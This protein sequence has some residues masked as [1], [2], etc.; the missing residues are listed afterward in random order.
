MLRDELS[1]LFQLAVG[2]AQKSG[3][4]PAFELPATYEVQR[5]KQAEHGDYSCNAAMII[6]AAARKAGANLNPRQV[7]Q[8]ILDYLP[9]DDEIGSAEIA[10]PGFIN[11]RLGDGW[12]QQQVNTIVQAD[13]AFGNSQRG[14]GQYWQVEFVSANPTGPIHY[15]GA[16][17]AVLGESVSRVLEASGY[18]VQREFY[19][20]DGGSQFQK[21][22]ESLYARYMQG[23]GHEI[24]IPEDGYPGEYMLDYAQLVRDQVGDALVGL[25]AEQAIAD[26]KPLGREIVL[27]SLK[28]ELGRV[29][30]AFDNWASEQ[31]LYDEGLV[32]QSIDYLDGRGELYKHEG[33]VWFRASAYPGIDK[34][35]VIVRSNG[36]PTYLAGDIAYHYDKFIRRGFDHVIDVLSVD[37]QGHVPRLKAI[38]QAFGLEPERL[39]CLIYDLVK[40]VRDGQEVKLSKRRGNL[41]TINDVVYEVGSDALHFNLLSR[42]PESVIEFDLDLAVAQNSENPVYYVQYGHARICSIMAKARAEGFTGEGYT[43][44]TSADLTLLT[45]PAELTL[46]RKVLE[47]EEQIETAVERLSPH[48][49]AHYAIELTRTFNAFYRDCKVVDA[50]N[51]A[52][53]RARLRLCEAARI[54]IAKTLYLLGVSAP[55]SM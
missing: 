47:L 10:G 39:T 44:E 15:G 14:A 4:L 35:W 42:A 24:A 5:P 36:R 28:D 53:S 27:E 20:N 45:H 8:V 34:D 3:A 38:V 12:L 21:F 26:I 31:A 16:R 11:L 52:L 37:H 33:A 17:N 49:L 22:A 48:N 54:G 18:R 40:L 25:S 30:V 9:E 55:E 7:A 32:Q 13:M 6:A 43:G 50:E 1:L 19:V 23:F 51:L 46:I 41:V 29:G 2:A